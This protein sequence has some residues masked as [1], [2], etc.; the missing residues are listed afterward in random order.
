MVR[1]SVETRLARLEEQLK[2]AYRLLEDLERDL[3]DERSDLRE[4]VRAG[5][6]VIFERLRS[7][8]GAVESIEKAI[9]LERERIKR[10]REE[11][12]KNR[13]TIAVAVIAASGTILAAIVAAAVA[14]FNAGGHP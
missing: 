11:R 8:S 2:S 12:G 4:L 6:E 5:D 10:E 13:T 3:R 1:D 9:R 7:L 14:I